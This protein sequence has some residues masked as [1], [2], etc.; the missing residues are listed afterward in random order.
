MNAA[1]SKWMKTRTCHICNKKELIAR[2]C[3]NKKTHEV[4]DT[5]EK[6]SDDERKRRLKGKRNSL[7]LELG[8]QVSLKMKNK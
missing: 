8:A 7:C 6:S 1:D 4:K 2:A 5:D 3:R